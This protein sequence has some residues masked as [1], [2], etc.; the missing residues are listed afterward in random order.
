MAVAS[1]LITKIPESVYTYKNGTPCNFW[2]A[3]TSC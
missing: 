3:G 1:S 2:S